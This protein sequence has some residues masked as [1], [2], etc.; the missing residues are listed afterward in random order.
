MRSRV[1]PVVVFTEV[2]DPVKAERFVTPGD[3]AF[4]HPAYGPS[5]LW[6]DEADPTERAPA[7]RKRLEAFA[8]SGVA[9]WMPSP[10]ELRAALKAA[11]VK[12]PA[13]SRTPAWAGTPGS[14]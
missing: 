5:L 14:Y 11:G 9:S 4:R 2:P 8:R 3:R 6:G 10:A 12:K 1:E 13:E 7:E